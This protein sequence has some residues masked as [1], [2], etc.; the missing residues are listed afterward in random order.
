MA[1]SVMDVAIMLN[2]MRSPFGAVAGESSG[3]KSGDH[4]DLPADYTAF[5]RPGAMHGARI[6]IDIQWRTA[7]HMADRLRKGEM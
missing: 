1:R 6:G 4:G 5:V 3:E 7:D 2:A